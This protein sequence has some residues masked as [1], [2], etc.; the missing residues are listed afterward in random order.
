MVEITQLQWTIDE[1]KENT[2][3]ALS[4][5]WEEKQT[6]SKEDQK[7]RLYVSREQSC[8]QWHL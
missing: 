7:C 5:E 2:A 4:N 1:M 6:R 3:S 8:K